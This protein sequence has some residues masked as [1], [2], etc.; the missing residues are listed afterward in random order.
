VGH[1]VLLKQQQDF[2]FK[3]EQKSFWLILTVTKGK[4]FEAELKDQGYGALFVKASI[5][6]EEQV[7][8]VFS[9]F[10]SIKRLIPT[11]KE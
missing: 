7:A 6:N 2:L 5:T 9:I 8:N 1:L 10:N 11:K 3:R 4:E